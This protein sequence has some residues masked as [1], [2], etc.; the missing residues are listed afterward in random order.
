MSNSN[1][2][3]GL[4]LQP[5]YTVTGHFGTKTVRH[6]YRMV[7][8]CLE[9]LPD[10]SAPVPKYLETLRHHPSKIHM[11]YCFVRI[12]LLLGLY[13]EICQSYNYN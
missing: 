4:R 2:S 6:H 10:T 12:G 13:A 3:I 9:T 7:P 8:K 5:V 11:G 1:Y